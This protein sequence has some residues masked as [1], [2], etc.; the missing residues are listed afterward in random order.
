MRVGVT[1]AAG[2]QLTIASTGTVTDFYSA[3]TSPAAVSGAGTVGA[4]GSIV[5]S[6]YGVQFSAGFANRLILT[7]GVSITGTVSGGNTIGATATSTLEL[8]SGASTGTLTGLGSRY[9]N[10]GQIALDA[11]AR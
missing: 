11:D 10:F 8:A 4:A 2:A 9:V 6:T 1:L 3:L 5:A 7:P